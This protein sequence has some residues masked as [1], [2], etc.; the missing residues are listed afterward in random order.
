MTRCS[1][2]AHDEPPAASATLPGR[3]D[4]AADLAKLQE[5]ERQTRA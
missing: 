4:L 2:F 3:T 1:Q 5:I